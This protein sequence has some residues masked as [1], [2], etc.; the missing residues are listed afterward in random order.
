MQKLDLAVKSTP[1][2]LTVN[3]EEMT[4]KLSEYSEKYKGLIITE[5]TLPECK[6]TQKELKKIRNEIEIH[7]KNIKREAL[8]PITDFETK[9]KSLVTIIDDVLTPIKNG[10]AFYT[11]QEKDAKN[12]KILALIKEL[13]AEYELTEKFQ[14]SLNIEK[15]PAEFQNKTFSLK[16]IKN[17]LISACINQKTEQ[18]RRK[19]DI[20]SIENHLALMNK[21]NNIEMKLNDF[22]NIETDEIN[23]AGIVTEITKRATSI[24]ESIKKAEKLRIEK[25]KA[26]EL[27]KLINYRIGKLSNYEYKIFQTE[28]GKMTL[29]EFDTFLNNTKKNHDEKQEKIKLELEQKNKAEKQIIEPVIEKNIIPINEPVDHTVITESS[30]TFEQFKPEV[31]E[32]L[33]FTI[34]VSNFDEYQKILTFCKENN[35]EIKDDLPF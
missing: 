31:K 17:S 34:S 25:E 16:K 24:S 28:L 32:K 4:K 2:I 33:I 15:H 27:Q 35:I 13:N 3:F 8:I 18:N 14:L 21:T 30:G 29:R 19:N 11:Q 20:E 7:R 26:K 10:I 1:A 23:V 22:V 5:Q 12:V 9:M 6:D